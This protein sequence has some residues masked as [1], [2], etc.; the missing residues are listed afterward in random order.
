MELYCIFPTKYSEVLDMSMVNMEQ[1]ML[2]IFFENG[3]RKVGTSSLKRIKES[4]SRAFMQPRRVSIYIREN[5]SR[6]LHIIY[7][8]FNTLILITPNYISLKQP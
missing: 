5:N 8:C 6:Y 4:F 2:R 1:K 7:S 3:I